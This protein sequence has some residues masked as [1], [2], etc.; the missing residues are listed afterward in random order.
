MKVEISTLADSVFQAVKGYCSAEFGRMFERA[1]VPFQK[2]L[3]EIPAGKDGLPGERGPQGEK[4]MDGAAGEQGVQGEPGSPGTD[5][6]PGERGPQGEKGLDGLPG[7]RGLQGEP[8]RD[9]V[10]GKDGAHGEQGPIGLT[11]EK[12]EP[13]LNGKDGAPGADGAPGVQGEKGDSGADGA[14]G[15]D[16]EKGADGTQ[17]P[18]GEPGPQ[19]DKGD[20]GD[21]GEPGQK[22][23]DG[24]VGEPGRDGRDG[25]EGIPGRDAAQLEILPA[26]DVSR[27][28]P[29][30]TY[31]CWNGGLIRSVR[32]TEP[33]SDS[34]EAAGWAVV[35]E[36]ISEFDVEQVT[37]RS[38][39]IKVVM[40]GGRVMEK[41]VS[42]PVLLDKGV[43]KADESYAPGDVTTWDGS[44]W[45]ARE[46]TQDKPGTSD[47]WR[48]SVKRGRDG[49]DGLKGEKGE[50]GAEG[51]AGKDLTQMTMDGRRF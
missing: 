41:Q 34:I 3:E 45:I 51:R 39:K 43:F 5:G 23:M 32:T 19:G 14:P 15:R 37:E 18:Q 11:G 42:M 31:A 2:R 28:Y 46:A 27:S 30:A 48:L 21:P 13:G 20:K 4:G 17:G 40:T 22:G 47:A 35:I 44:M 10:N 1:I 16:G 12:G 38:F 36:G 6:A 24:L 33:V 8:G 9:G 7:E 29:R 26:I 49:R 25:K 50:R